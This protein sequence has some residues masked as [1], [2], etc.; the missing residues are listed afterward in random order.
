MAMSFFSFQSITVW[1]IKMLTENLS[2]SAKGS[3]YLR[4]KDWNGENLAGK[5][6]TGRRKIAEQWPRKRSEHTFISGQT[7][8]GELFLI[9]EWNTNQTLKK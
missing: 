4:L 2:G 9:T 3:E 1:K 6:R 7:T 5:D 8:A